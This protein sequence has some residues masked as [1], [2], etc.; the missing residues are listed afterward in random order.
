ML[1]TLAFTRSWCGLYPKVWGQN[2]HFQ[3]GLVL[4]IDLSVPNKETNNGKQQRKE[5]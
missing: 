3:K 5:I 2:L 1:N 4:V